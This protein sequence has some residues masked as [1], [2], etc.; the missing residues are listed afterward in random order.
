M[1][2]SRKQFNKTVKIIKDS[3]EI[4]DYFI[5]ALVTRKGEPTAINHNYTGTVGGGIKLMGTVYQQLVRTAR[6]IE[7]RE[8]EIDE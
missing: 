3:E 7:E 6:E 1:E 2:D 5:V 8:H 4:S